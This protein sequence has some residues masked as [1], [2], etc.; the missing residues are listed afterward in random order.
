[1]NTFQ[2]VVECLVKY[3]PG[4]GPD[5]AWELA[6]RIDSEGAAVVWSGPLEQ[7]EL[8]HQQ[9]AMEGLTMAPLERA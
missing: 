5:S 6:H 3:L 1:V 4:I 7:A 2:H 9:L 8:Y